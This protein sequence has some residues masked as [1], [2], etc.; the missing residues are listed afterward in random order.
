MLVNKTKAA[1]LAGV[2]RRTFYNHIKGKNISLTRD[3]DGDE[4]I[5]IAEL[6]RIYGN[7]KILKNLQKGEE[8]KE[9]PEEG[10][11]PSTAKT[12]HGFTGSSVNYENLLLKEKLKSAEEMIA[13][14]KSERDHLHLS[15]EHTKEQL[16]KALQIGAPIGRLLEDQRSSKDNIVEEQKSRIDQMEEM[17]KGL[18]EQND[19]MVQLEEDRRKCQLP[20]N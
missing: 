13:Q 1:E 14:L 8:K 4:K 17:I 3:E 16:D 7:E 6:K 19:R 2:S 12:S 10:G 20:L 9:N 18:K 15:H 11:K 5:D